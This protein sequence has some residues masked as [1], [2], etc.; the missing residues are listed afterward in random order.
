MISDVA[1][2]VPTKDRPDLLRQLLDALRAQRLERFPTV[3]WGVVVVDN[4]D[5]GSAE[6]VVGDA[7][8]HGGLSVR[9]VREPQVGLANARNRCLEEA[10]GADAVAFLDDDELPD[11]TWL[12]ELLAVQ[13]ATGADAVG[14]P[15]LALLPAA[16]PRWLRR[17][18]F[19]DTPRAR[20]ATGSVLS[21]LGA[22]NVLITAALAWSSGLLFNE[23]LNVVGG[24]DSVYFR[25]AHLQGMKLV[26]ADDATVHEHVP[27]ERVALRWVLRRAR[28]EGAIVVRRNQIL[29][30]QAPLVLAARSVGFI[31]LGG[32]AAIVG[33]VTG[34]SVVA[35]SGMR[36]AADGLGRLF[37]FAGRVPEHYSARRSHG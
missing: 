31:A 3:S 17:G 28:R 19:L 9:Y 22:G 13:R 11:A 30:E 5:A 23:Q 15:V 16:S 2:C 8:E 10:A 37:A 20:P 7:A 36:R 1:V 14:G 4:S 29:K 18:R 34:R 35:V 24:E 25:A 21:E 26:W 6:V 32:A 33:G 12:D 27:N